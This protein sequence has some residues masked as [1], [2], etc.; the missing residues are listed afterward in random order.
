MKQML[1][2]ILCFVLVLSMVSGTV[3]AEAFASTRKEVYLPEIAI[4]NDILDY[5]VFYI[6][7]AS[8]MVQENGDC[9]YLLRIGRGGSAESESSVL[10]K[11]ADMTAKYGEDYIVRIHD[12]STDVENP[13]DNFSLM[14][15]INGSDFEQ[16]TISDDTINYIFVLS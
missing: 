11:I 4:G 15:M 3:P 6:A 1:R 14:E 8:A 7:T 12:G 10:V 13:E 2:R 5:D 9:A 16:N